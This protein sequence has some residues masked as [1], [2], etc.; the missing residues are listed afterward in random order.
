[1]RYAVTVRAE[2]THNLT[3]TDECAPFPGEER[4]VI[5]PI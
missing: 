1:M 5:S 3:N 4:V 2:K